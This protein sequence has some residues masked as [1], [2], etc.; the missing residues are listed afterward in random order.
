V[1]EPEGHECCKIKIAEFKYPS[2]KHTVVWLFDHSS[3]HRAFAE[4]ALNAKVM[5]VKPGGAQRCM[6][7]TVWAGRVQKIPPGHEKS[8]GGEGHQHFLNGC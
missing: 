1:D 4:D 2:D 5:N 6:R 8:I 7:D 3:C